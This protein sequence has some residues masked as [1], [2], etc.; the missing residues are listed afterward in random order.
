MTQASSVCIVVWQIIVEVQLQ[1]NFQRRFIPKKI[2]SAGIN[3]FYD[4]DMDRRS[5]E[6]LH[7]KDLKS[8]LHVPKN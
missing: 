3:P 4:G 5:K 6:F 2:T 7:S 1:N 8:K